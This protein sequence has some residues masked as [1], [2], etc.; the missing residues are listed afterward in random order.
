MERMYKCRC[1]GKLIE[2]GEDLWLEECPECKGTMDYAFKCDLCGEW[3]CD[4][5]EYEGDHVCEECVENE[6]SVENVLEYA[7]DEEE[8]VSINGFLAYFFTKEE[9]NEILT[10]VLYKSRDAGSQAKRFVEE[11]YDYVDFIKRKRRK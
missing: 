2:S 1:C 4:S 6:I 8:S 9:I 10:D 3:K 5:E 11:S 7:S